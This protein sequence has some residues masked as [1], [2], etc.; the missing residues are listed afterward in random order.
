MGG[1]PR[2]RVT[3]LDQGSQLLAS[4]AL[5]TERSSGEDHNRGG[6]GAQRDDIASLGVSLRIQTGA[7][8]Q[9]PPGGR[10]GPTLGS[11]TS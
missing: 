11:L 6:L 1:V 2:H 9:V 7:E 4:A 10:R 8:R 5:R 3:H